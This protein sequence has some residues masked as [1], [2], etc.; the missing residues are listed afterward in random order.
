[1]L[2]PETTLRVR[3]IAPRARRVAAVQKT[4]GVSP[5]EAEDWVDRRDR[6]RLRFVDYY[7]HSNAAD[8]LLYDLV[9][10]SERLSSDECADLIVQ[11][12]HARGAHAPLRKV[13]AV[14]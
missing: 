12:V 10:N 13:M 8:P 3:V 7:F 2:P 9:L 14:I 5:A 1:M 11:A 4:R 6:E